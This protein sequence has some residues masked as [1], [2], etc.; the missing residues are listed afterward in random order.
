MNINIDDRIP[1]KKNV[2]INRYDLSIIIFHYFRNQR[3][4]EVKEMSYG[5]FF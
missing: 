3:S 1:F 5:F 2:Y 4:V